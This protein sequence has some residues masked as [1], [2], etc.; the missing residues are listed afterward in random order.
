MKCETLDVMNGLGVK[1][2]PQ[3]AA[4]LILICE[5][6]MHSQVH[7]CIPHPVPR[8]CSCVSFTLTY[9]VPLLLYYKLHIN[10]DEYFLFFLFLLLYSFDAKE[11]D[12]LQ[13]M[14]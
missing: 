11:K 7:V 13:D 4:V 8:A 3:I 9:N 2:R 1:P 12:R 5:H 10:T 6:N 14:V